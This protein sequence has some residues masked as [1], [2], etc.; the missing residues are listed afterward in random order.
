[1]R[2]HDARTDAE[3]VAS[4]L[5][6]YRSGGLG[7]AGIEATRD[8]LIAGQVDELYLTVAADASADPDGKPT[9]AEELIALAART[10]ATTRFIEDPALLA[11]VGGV[12]AALRFRM[13][14]ASTDASNNPTV[15]GATNQ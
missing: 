9:E 15:K 10:A 14:P 3:V 4:V 7:A 12:A 6:A 2:R 8:A 1:M 5:D 13:K 11:D